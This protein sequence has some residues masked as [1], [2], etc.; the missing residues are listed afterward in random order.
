MSNPFNK[1]SYSSIQTKDWTDKSANSIIKI[2]S[3]IRGLEPRVENIL[4]VAGPSGSGKSTFIDLLASDRLDSQLRLD[5]P[6][7]VGDWPSFEANDVLKTGSW[8]KLAEALSSRASGIIFALRYGLLNHRMDPIW[9]LLEKA[10]QLRVVSIEPTVSQL[11]MQ[12][13]K[14]FHEQMKR[15]GHFRATWHQ[16]F[17]IP[18]KRLKYRLIRL[19]VPDSDLIYRRPE[20]IRQWYKEWADSIAILN[21]SDRL[22]SVLRLVPA[23]NENGERSFTAKRLEHAQH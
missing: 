21:E 13:D 1:K 22:A 2:K 17:K 3:S 9:P 4:L 14:R 19:G 5:L 15:K 8:S 6:D 23:S 18:I 11:R 16:L 12:F 10:D 7:G 20:C